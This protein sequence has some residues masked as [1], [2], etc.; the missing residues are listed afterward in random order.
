MKSHIPANVVVKDYH[1]I[2]TD[3][4]ET[5]KPILLQKKQKFIIG[6]SCNLAL[7][8]A[9]GGADNVI[10]VFPFPIQIAKA[11]KNP[12]EIAGFHASHVR[13]AV[14]L[15]S[16]FKWLESELLTGKEYDEVQVSDVL[17]G[18]RR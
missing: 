12:V 4:A 8:D 13:D 2:F 9:V 18:L 5:F 6:S 1:Q 3:L 14:A 16:F 15:C 11:I 17:E 7:V 10:S